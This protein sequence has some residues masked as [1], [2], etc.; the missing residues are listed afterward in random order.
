MKFGIV[1]T[2]AIARYHAA[3][4]R[5]H[6]EGELA[7]VCGISLDKAA[8][9]ADGDAK[10][11]LFDDYAKM[12]ELEELDVVC[13]CTPSGLHGKGVM[14]AA[15][16]GKHVLCEKPLEVAAERMTEMIHACRSR[17]L[18]LGCVFQ[19]RLMPA[20]LHARQALLDGK[21][22]KPVMANAYLKYYRSREYY[23][24][25]GWRGT[26]EFDGGGALMNQGIH[27]I[28]LLQYMMGEVASVFAYCPTLVRDIEVEDTAVVA[29]KFKSG[30]LGV[31]QGATSVYPGQETRFELHGDK[32]TI[33]F[34]DEGIKQWKFMG[35]EE[36]APAY[37]D[38]LGF[39]ATSS[40]AQ[41]L[42]V[43]G[44]YFY[45]ND[46]I[47]AVRTGREPHVNGEEARK[48]VDLILAIYESARSGQEVILR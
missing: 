47:E 26:R 3:A 41:Q 14:L 2:G 40:S 27:G 30:A 37:E 28:D 12:L 4:I 11:K 44:H 21:L 33:E 18:K 13:V 1:G 35:S 46:M 45:I 43:A 20:M 10:V 22:G 25:G 29:L 17:S 38:T 5:L 24:S 42:P 16:A 8:E 9:L 32:G 7:A 39:G 15:R 31:I 36:A 48:S 6:P 34:G 23:Q 19:R